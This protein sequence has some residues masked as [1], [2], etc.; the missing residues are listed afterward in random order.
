MSDI[1]TFY[2]AIQELIP[3]TLV[4]SET[5]TLRNYAVDGLLPRLVVTPATVE[6]TA[7]VVALTNQ[8]GLTLLARGGGS[9]I[10]VGGPP[11]PIDVLLETNKLTRLLEYESPDLTCHVE[12]GITLANLQAQLAPKGQLL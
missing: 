1:D 2:T 7:H 12:A 9:R 8:H 10:S 5:S 3:G 11:E 4:T 6:Q